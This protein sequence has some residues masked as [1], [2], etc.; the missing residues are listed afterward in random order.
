[1]KKIFMIAVVL[2]MMHGK[3]FCEVMTGVTL[4]TPGIIN[5]NIGYYGDVF[6]GSM[7]ISFLHLIDG[8][9]DDNTGGSYSD[10]RENTGLSFALMQFNIDAKIYDS[11]NMIFALSAAAGT[12]YLADKADPESDITVFY[13]GPCMHLI[14]N[15]LYLELGAAYGK[16]FSAKLEEEK[17]SLFPLIQIGY[18]ARI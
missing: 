6:G 8:W 5:Y 12:F 17:T 11:G 15:G 2:L 9:L 7:S 10:T 3:G 4:G 1:M 18:V 13:A 14:W 16:D